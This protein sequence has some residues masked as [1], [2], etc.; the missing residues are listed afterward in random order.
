MMILGACLAIWV[1]VEDIAA[2]LSIL[3]RDSFF[4]IFYFVKYETKRQ[5]R[6]CYWQ[7][8]LSG[9][10]LR[11]T[12]IIIIVVFH[13]LLFSNRVQDVN[14]LLLLLFNYP[15]FCPCF[16][17]FTCCCY[18]KTL[19]ICSLSPLPVVLLFSFSIAVVIVSR[20]FPIQYM[21]N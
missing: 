8:S 19:F 7:F 4:L 13:L 18:C 5:N 14:L 20:L 17:L 15:S 9:L 21:E 6:C 11:F 3:S 2:M 16:P 10:C 12:I 1:C